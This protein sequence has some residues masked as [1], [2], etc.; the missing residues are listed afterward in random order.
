MG[1]IAP[2]NV[3]VKYRDHTHHDRP[4]SQS[5]HVQKLYLPD[6]PAKFEINVRCQQSNQ[7]CNLVQM[8]LLAAL[9]DRHTEFNVALRTMSGKETAYV[10]ASGVP[11][12]TSL[13]GIGALE[14]DAVGGTS[15]VNAFLMLVAGVS[16]AILAFATYFKLSKRRNAV[17]A[18]EELQDRQPLAGV[19]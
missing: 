7:Q 18:S 1:N 2:Q 3:A 4:E 14:E 10:S 6:G 9:R 8:E 17:V 13:S 19:E 12:I 11:A 5:A 16:M 15:A